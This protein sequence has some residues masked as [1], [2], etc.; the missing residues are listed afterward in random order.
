[1]SVGGVGFAAEQQKVSR[2]P[3][4]AGQQGSVGFNKIKTHVAP[5]SPS[6]TSPG[7][8]RSRPARYGRGHRPGH[9]VHMPSRGRGPKAPG[10]RPPR[11][12]R[13][14]V[15]VT[16]IRTVLQSPCRN[17]RGKAV[18][19]LIRPARQLL[20]AGP[21]RLLFQAGSQ[22]AY[23]ASCQCSPPETR[24]PTKARYRTKAQHS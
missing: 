5:L 14:L 19:F 7:P 2:S 11:H 6:N 8:V 18:P 17:G 16:L 9:A 20:C 3:V 15:S 1:M 21:G 13:A 10:Q 22:D 23:P 24:C 12:R 4:C